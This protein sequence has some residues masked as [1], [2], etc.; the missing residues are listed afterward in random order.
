M[1]PY[2]A[3]AAAHAAL[4]AAGLL[5]A[6]S[7]L[8]F[9]KRDFCMSSAARPER[10]AGKLRTP[11]R[12]AGLVVAVL[13]VTTARQLAEGKTEVTAADAAAE[14][15]DWAE[16]IG[17]ARGAEAVAPGSPWPERGRLRLESIGHDAEAR[18]DDPTA[19]LAYGALRAAVLATRAAGADSDRWRRQ[20]ED[21]LARVASARRDV[22][23]PHA[24]ASASAMLD[25]LRD[26]E[27]PPAWR[28]DGARRVMGAAMLGGLA[29]LAWLGEAAAKTARVAQAIAGAGLVA[30]VVVVLTQ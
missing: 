29:R 26:S 6:S 14:R 28:L 18:G 17:R 10:S 4:Y 25:D 12:A 20:A 15:S 5:A 11:T 24:T 27:P 16:A 30:Y 7:R 23:A 22:D 13:A 3:L 9:R 21:S 2:V 1:W 19:L 8:V